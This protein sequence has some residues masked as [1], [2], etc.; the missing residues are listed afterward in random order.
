MTNFAH[1]TRQCYQA[2]CRLEQCKEAEAAYKRELRRRKREAVGEF[3][4][5]PG[6]ALSLISGDGTV[7]PASVSAGGG[8]VEAAVQ[9]EIDALGSDR[10]GLKATAV[11]L[12]KILDNPKA[13]S[14]QPAAAA[15]LADILGE[16][17]KNSSGRRSKL[18]EVR[19]MTRANAG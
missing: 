19:S 9:A 5:K 3:A 16:L 15:K 10:G 17:R 14:T 2:G 7:T 13:I 11:A 12:A 1:G 6:P 4:T 18:A 8:V